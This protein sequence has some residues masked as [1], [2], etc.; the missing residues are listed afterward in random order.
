MNLIENFSVIIPLYN[1]ECEIKRTVRS[2]L[3]QTVKD[4][5][6]IIIDDGSTDNTHKLA[7]VNDRQQSTLTGL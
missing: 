2:V 5:E 4:F 1:K 6:L 7:S 3:A